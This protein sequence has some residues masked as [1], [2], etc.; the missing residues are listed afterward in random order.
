[1][2]VYFHAF[3]ASVLDGD[4]AVSSQ[5]YTMTT[6]TIGK[7]PRTSLDVVARRKTLLQLRIKAKPSIL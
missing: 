7:S 2:E 1:V 6:V 3:Q 4:E 5:F